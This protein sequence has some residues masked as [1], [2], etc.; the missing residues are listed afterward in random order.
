MP[1]RRFRRQY[2]QLSQFEKGRIIGMMEAGWS[3]RRV[4]RQLGRSDCVMRRCWDQWILEMSFTRRPVVEKTATSKRIA[5]QLCET[6]GRQVSQFT[7]ARR[8][9]KGDLFTGNP[10]RCTPFKVGHRR[11]RLEWCKEHKNWSSHQWGRV[12]FTD[13]SHFNA[14]SDSQRQLT[15][16]EVGARFHSSNIT[17]KDCYGCPGVVVWGGIILNRW[18]E[19]HVWDRGSVTGDR[20]CKEVILPHVHLFRGAI[21]PNFVSMVENS[22]PHYTTYIQQL[23]ESED[24]TQMD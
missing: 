23:L 17:E 19:L 7:V 22:R 12:L 20:F 2:E 24:I 5:Q 4:A 18:T 9:H 6:T 8:L 13:E 1:L 14:T 21:G 3:A 11:H 16:R 10:E 15:W